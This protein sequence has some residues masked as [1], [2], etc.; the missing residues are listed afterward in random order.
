MDSGVYMHDGRTHLRNGIETIEMYFRKSLL[1]KMVQMTPNGVKQWLSS[2]G[3][4]K[5]GPPRAEQ[6]LSIDIKE[7]KEDPDA[8]VAVMR[9]A[10]G[11]EIFAKWY[12]RHQACR[13]LPTRVTMTKHEN[14]QEVEF[15]CDSCE[16]KKR[17]SAEAFP[18]REWMNYDGSDHWDKM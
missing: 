13:P 12:Y 9:V 7:T 11:W 3:Y 18:E 14:A 17:L 2:G 10:R 8:Y 4:H 1:Q 5:P 6:I 16:E 15:W